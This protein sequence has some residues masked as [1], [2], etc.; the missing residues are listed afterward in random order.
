MDLRPHIAKHNITQ[1]DITRI[2]GWKQSATS[3]IIRGERQVPIKHIA[4]FEKATGIPRKVFRPE[5]YK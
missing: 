1:A 2:M 3:A 5:L 4:A